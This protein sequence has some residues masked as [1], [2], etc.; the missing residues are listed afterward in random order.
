[1]LPEGLIND[2]VE[3][4]AKDIHHDYKGKDLTIFVIMKSAFKF[5][6]HLLA[7][8]NKIMEHTG[9]TIN[10]QLHFFKITT[11]HLDSSVVA[12]DDVRERML[13]YIETSSVLMKFQIMYAYRSRSLLQR[14]R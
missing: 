1:M 7:S 10:L 4:M 3:K 11:Y 6:T 13:F 12:K 14:S 9:E 5:F 8:L 2:R